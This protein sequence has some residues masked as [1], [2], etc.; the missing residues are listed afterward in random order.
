[1]AA[2]NAGNTCLVGN[3]SMVRDMLELMSQNNDTGV[4]DDSN[5]KGRTV[6]H[7]AVL[8][9]SSATHLKVGFGFL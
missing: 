1:M 2:V 7:M 3:S 4:L 9:D 5:S 6:L 8:A